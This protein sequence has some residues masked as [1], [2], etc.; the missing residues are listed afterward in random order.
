MSIC[1]VHLPA[2]VL[3]IGALQKFKTAI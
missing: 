3:F 1:G 2:Q